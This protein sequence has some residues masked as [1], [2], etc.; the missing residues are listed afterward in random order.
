M[1]DTL[2]RVEPRARQERRRRKALRRRLGIGGAVAL[3]LVILS[4]VLIAGLGG[5]DADPTPIPV[6]E[7]AE[8]GQITY[9][10]VGTR[11]DETTGAADWITVLAVDREGTRPVTLFVPTSTL[12][13]IPGFGFDSV[14]KALALGRLPLEEVTV[15]N[16]LG[17][18]ID[19]TMIVAEQLISRLV[20]LAGGIEVDVPERLLAPSG[21]NRLV[22]V[23]EKGKQRLDGARAVRYLQFEGEGSELERAV[24]AQQVWE[25]IYRRFE[26]D[27]AADLKRIMTTLLTAS[28]VT[29]APP[30]D[31][32]AFIGAFAAVGEDDRSY[33]T[34]PV[35]A[36]GG[37]G[38]EDAF[39]VQ[40]TRL[41][42][43]VRSLLAESLPPDGPGR[44]ARVQILNGNGQPEVGLAV[45]DLLIPSGFRIADTG[46]ARSFEF[47][48]TRIVVYREADIPIAQRIRALLGVGTIEISRTQQSI[49]DVTVVV[50]RDFVAKQ[51]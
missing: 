45:A 16:L 28:P 38:A 36:V 42:E 3:P 13:E 49:V 31:A 4:I 40:Q 6:G 44:G 12:T 1:T 7:G 10:L 9:L 14:G 47:V 20:D 35:E 48:R 15:E 19:H 5:G 50:G 29:D 23:F 39:R 8:G 22:P 41:D 17:I 34:L 27:K 43:L 21:A 2:P 46:N 51:S 37:G 25:G 11:A 30:K 33:R 26:G 24:R 32:G 18:T